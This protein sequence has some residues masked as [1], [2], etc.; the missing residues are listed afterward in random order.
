M[1]PCIVGAEII[2]KSFYDHKR[3]NVALFHLFK[4][5][6]LLKTFQSVNLLKFVVS[7]LGANFN[8]IKF[9]RQWNISAK[10]TLN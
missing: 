3:F 1:I 6:F 5:Y 2:R 7:Y 10:Y 8:N 9:Y 4:Y